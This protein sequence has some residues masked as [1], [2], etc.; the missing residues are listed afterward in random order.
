MEGGSLTNELMKRFGCRTDIASTSAFV[1]QR[2]KILPEAF[3][4]IFRM[5]VEESDPSRLYNVYRLF[6]VDGSDIQIP[7]NPQDK[8]SYFPG[9]NGQHPYNLLHLNAMYD[10][11]QRT[12]VD[13]IVQKR[14]CC[15]ECRSLADMVDRSS[16]KQPAIIIADRAYESYNVLAHIQENCTANLQL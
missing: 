6:A 8:D 10:L 4:T 1:Q 3:E 15:D 5:F 11:L 14:H 9:S 12:Y 16:V 13:A 2:G 7:T